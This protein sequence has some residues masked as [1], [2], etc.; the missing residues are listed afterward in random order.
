[1]TTKALSSTG[2]AVRQLGLFAFAAV[3]GLAALMWG[4]NL[5]ANLTAS[6]S[7]A[8]SAVDAANNAITVLLREEP[9]QL[10]STRSTDQVSGVVL[11]HVMEGLLRY[12]ENNALVPGMAESWRIDTE[13]A[14]FQLRGGRP[15]ERRASPSPPMTSC[16]L[17]AWCWT[18]TTP[19]NTPSFCTQ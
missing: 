17:G 3:A 1:M 9:P 6:A 12:D 14:L 2:L 15:L 7:G 13:G 4:L 19:P 5:L 18:R 11:G 10:D 16:S 8:N